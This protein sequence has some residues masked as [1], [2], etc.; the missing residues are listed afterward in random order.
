MIRFPNKKKV[1][2]K[3]GKEKPI[4]EFYCHS[5]MADGYFNKCKDCARKDAL[6]YRNKNLERIRAY[7]RQR[8]KLPHRK[9][10]NTKR[11]KLQR[12]L[13]PQKYVAQN[14]VSNAIRDEKIKKPKKCSKCGRKN[15]RIYG[16]HEDYYKPLEVIW[17]CQICHREEHQKLQKKHREINEIKKT[18]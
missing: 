1:C 5:Q 8:G 4:I 7:D 11:N 15:C 14:M 10:A 17:L 9:K 2:F 18:K 16:H 6:E 3:C 13:Y 12:K